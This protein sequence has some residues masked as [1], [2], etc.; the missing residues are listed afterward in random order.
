MKEEINAAPRVI[1]LSGSLNSPM[2]KAFLAG[3]FSGTCSTVLFQPL[4]L[5]KTKIQANTETRVG[6][7]KMTRNVL[8]TESIGG[9]WKGLVPSIV[10]TVPGVG[11]Y[12]SAMHAMKTGLCDGKPS[13]MASMV[14]GATARCMAGTIMIPA[15]VIK[16][17]YESGRFEYRGIREAFQGIYKREGVRGL[18]SGILPTLFRDA[19]FSGL[20]LM[21][22]NN[23]KTG[24][25]A[26]APYTGDTNH[27]FLC[28]LTAGCLA[29][30]LTHPA[31]VLKT[32]MQLNPIKKTI[33]E[34]SL[35]VFQSS[36]MKGFMTGLAPRML[37]RSLMASLAWSVYEK[38]MKNIGI[39]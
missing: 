1:L 36:G 7:M 21:L 14:I 29:S 35:A 38:A 23:L 39:K 10:R 28:G 18:T 9:L 13:S 24:F 3:S 37:R 15:T 33:T 19:P 34:A 26:L 12:F 20:Y 2:V 30:I 11:I 31:D 25:A 4:D 22:Y 8:S 17:R 27:H 5:L 16:I 32:H 6:M